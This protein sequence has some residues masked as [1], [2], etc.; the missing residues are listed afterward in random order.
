MSKSRATP[1][2]TTDEIAIAI[3]IG[4]PRISRPTRQT[5]KRILTITVISVFLK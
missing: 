2:A 5:A 1:P 3:Q 4:V